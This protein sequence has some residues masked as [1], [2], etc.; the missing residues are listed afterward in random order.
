MTD[1]IPDAFEELPEPSV[2][3]LANTLQGLCNE[4]TLS[5][6]E[7]LGVLEAVKLTIW[8]NWDKD[9]DEDDG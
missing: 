8:H 4:S 2:D 5:R 3:D 1:T 7:I 9:T 6:A